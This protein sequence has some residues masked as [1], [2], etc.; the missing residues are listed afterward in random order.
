MLGLTWA[1]IQ[2]DYLQSKTA[3]ACIERHKWLMMTWSANGWDYNRMQTLAKEYMSMHEEIW[4]GLAARVGEK[5]RVIEEKCMSRDPETSQ[6]TTHEAGTIQWD[7]PVKLTP[8]T[9][10]VIRARKRVPYHTCD[11]CQPPKVLTLHLLF[12]LVLSKHTL[13]WVYLSLP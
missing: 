6:N 10:R 12:A 11:V 8:I 7:P 1:E 9:G 5:W 2:E 4:S 13:T 3:N